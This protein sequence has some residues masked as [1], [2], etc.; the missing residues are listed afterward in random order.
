MQPETGWSAGQRALL[1]FLEQQGILTEEPAAPAA[2]R[3][4]NA[5]LFATFA[6]AIDQ[7]SL[8]DLVSRAL[9]IASVD[10]E[11]FA[12]MPDLVAL[13][14]VEVARRGE[15]IPI[16]QYDGTL[17][18]AAANPLDLET[19]KSVEFTTGLRVRTKV[20]LREDVCRA[21]REAYGMPAPAAVDES[22]EPVACGGDE[23]VADD[24]EMVWESPTA[25]ESAAWTFQAESGEA[26]DEAAV[27]DVVDA[28]DDANATDGDTDD[29]SG[30]E[31][32][33][34][35]GDETD[36]IWEVAEDEAVAAGDE[37]APSTGAGPVVPIEHEPLLSID[38]G[39]GDLGRFDDVR[40]DDPEPAEVEEPAE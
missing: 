22:P 8:V 18:L 15:V 32:R 34:V 19:V 10:L 30:I 21:L 26:G 33:A 1:R 37:P 9:R 23:P 27:T 24:G 3:P 28:S 13:V 7:R 6:D 39:T 29:A 40:L 38:D 14:P 31:W 36:P 25:P 16:A 2:G 12:P 11:G 17:E 35:D 4:T 20:A 5:D